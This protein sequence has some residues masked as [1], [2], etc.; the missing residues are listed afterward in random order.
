MKGLQGPVGDY[1][2]PPQLDSVTGARVGLAAKPDETPHGAHLVAQSATS[3]TYALPDGKFLLRTHSHAVNWQDPSGA[4]HRLDLALTK[5][6]DGRWRPKSSPV[7]TSFADTASAGA[8]K[9]PGGHTVQLD[10]T[11]WS[12]GFDVPSGPAATAVVA[13]GTASYSLGGGVTLDERAAVD[14][15]KEA[16][17]LDAAPL[18]S[19][20]VSYSFGLDVQ[21]VVPSVASTGMV[22]F[23]AKDGTVVASI[24]VGAAVDSARTIPATSPVAIELV[25]GPG[26]WVLKVTVLGSWVRDRARVF[27]VIVDPSLQ[28]GRGGSAAQDDAFVWDAYPTTT[29][30]GAA[31]YDPNLGNYV[32]YVGVSGSTNLNT[33]MKWNLAPLIGTNK[34]IVS[35]TLNMKVIAQS[36]AAGGSYSVNPLSQDFSSSTVTWNTQPATYL[37]ANGAALLSAAAVG[38][39]AVAGMTDV[40][41]HWANGSYP[42]FGG[43]AGVQ[44]TSGGFFSTGYTAFGAAEATGGADPILQVTYADLPPASVSWPAVSMCPGGDHRTSGCLPT[45]GTTTPKFTLAQPGNPAGHTVV[46]WYQVLDGMT[47]GSGASRGNYGDLINSGWVSSLSWSPPSG[48][49]V[50]GH[51]Y[52]VLVYTS[53]DGVGALPTTSF[54][55]IRLVAPAVSPTD[56]LGGVSVNLASGNPSLALGSQSFAAAGGPISLGL[57]YD[58]QRSLS[59][60]QGNYYSGCT[61][62]TSPWPTPAVT[63]TDPV[64]SFSWGND[65]TYGTPAV[66]V[67]P[68]GNFCALWQGNITVPYTGTWQLGALG[69]SDGIMIQLGSTVVL[70]DWADHSGSN[71]F[72][73]GVSPA[74][75]NQV[76]QAGVSYPIIIWYYNHATPQK[77][78]QI[79]LGV[80]G[81]I[82]A[83]GSSAPGQMHIVGVPAPWLTPISQPIAA[84][85][86]L[87]A[88]DRCRRLHVGH[89]DHGRGHH[90]YRGRAGA[91]LHVERHQLFAA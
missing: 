56:S 91:L 79:Q 2:S 54:V 84:G 11:G 42:T 20:D 66:G 27:P 38:A 34:G 18:G 17:R 13:S 15:V 24:P 48:S 16:I 63:R 90:Q 30:N 14:G 8:V 62:T 28:A 41:T 12:V 61:A 1:R 9:A 39:Q 57:D 26:A 33:L 21:G 72:C 52:T 59:G 74:A 47:A 4:F 31:Q 46:Y 40:V 32:D 50:D 77:S 81:P 37:S 45:V 68:P 70:S 88:A 78:A 35:A 55:T 80:A 44:L 64:V 23:T 6:S 53:V 83:D 49:L 36:P 85:W 82:N 87:S 73:T 22:V 75:C 67:V 3:D 29:W 51:T 89:G 10:G 58:P 69:V 7:A 5:G 19:G 65:A 43:W 60:L 76:L 25:G 86:R 71:E